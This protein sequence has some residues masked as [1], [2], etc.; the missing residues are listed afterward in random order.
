MG[1]HRHSEPACFELTKRL[2]I[3]IHGLGDP[4]LG[5]R[6]AVSS[7]RSER[8]LPDCSHSSAGDVLVVHDPQP[9]PLAGFLRPAVPL[10]T[11]WRSHRAGRAERRHPRRWEFLHPISSTTTR[12]FFRAGVHPSAS[13]AGQ[14]HPPG[15]DPLAPRTRPLAA[16]AIE[17][18][19]RGRSS[20]SGPDRRGPTS[21]ARRPG[22][23]VRSCR[24]PNGASR[25]HPP[26]VT[27]DLAV[28]D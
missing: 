16:G 19:C 21:A 7:G 9:L 18:L 11:I 3:L 24:E 22:R 12:V 23:T 10:V 17:V 26:I 13:P 6:T 15:I 27:P 20:L 14:G 1:R 4:R 5:R 2:Q 8:T 25:A 28:D